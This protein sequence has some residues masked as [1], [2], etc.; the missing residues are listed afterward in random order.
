M[1]GGGSR[2]RVKAD[3]GDL[4]KVIDILVQDEYYLNRISRFL[5]R[6]IVLDG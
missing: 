4:A 3:R 5:A 2:I 6:Y 1:A